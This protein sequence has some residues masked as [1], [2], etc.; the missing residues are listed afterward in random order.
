M[1]SCSL[2]LPQVYVVFSEELKCWCRALVESVWGHTDGYQLRCFLVDYAMYCS[3]ASERYVLRD[4]V[5][6]MNLLIDTDAIN[7]CLVNALV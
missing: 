7:I 2:S 1:V 3:V 5:T 6:V 4:F